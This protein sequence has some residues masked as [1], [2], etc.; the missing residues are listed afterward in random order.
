MDIGKHSISDLRSLQAQ[1]FHTIALRQHFAS[2]S[3]RASQSSDSNGCCE[4]Q[5][6]IRQAKG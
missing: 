5:V 3:H 2:P 4:G 6:K 1:W